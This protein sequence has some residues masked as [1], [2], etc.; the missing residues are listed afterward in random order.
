MSDGEEDEQSESRELF[1]RKEEEDSLRSC[2]RKG[3]RAQCL[4][5][6][7]FFAHF[8]ISS[9][10]HVTITTVEVLDLLPIKLDEF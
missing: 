5:E 1:S 10:N 4:P 2:S 8:H 9:L 6:R 3:K 7:C